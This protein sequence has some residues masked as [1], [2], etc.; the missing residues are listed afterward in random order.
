MAEDKKYYE[1]ISLDDLE[2]VSGGKIKL[3]GY[4]LLRAYMWQMKELDHNKE[5]TIEDFIDSW[6]KNC[7]FRTRFTDG[8]EADLETV[9]D[10]IDSW[11]KN[12]EF[13]TR[14]TD[15]T[16]ADLQSGIDFI[17]RYWK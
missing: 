14:F 10:F 12:C 1:E 13:R 3:T 17:N 4:A 7:E 16:D 9:E 15:G 8:T 6:N 11:N 2:K 5:E